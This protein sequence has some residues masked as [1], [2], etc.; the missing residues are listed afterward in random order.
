MKNDTRDAYR[1]A[2][3]LGIPRS[4]FFYYMLDD[5]VKSISIKNLKKICD[6]FQIPAQRMLFE[7]IE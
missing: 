6:H 2:E 5:G 3:Y 1:L 7:D 4:T